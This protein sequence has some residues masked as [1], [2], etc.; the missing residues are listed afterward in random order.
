MPSTI[1]IYK[2]Q[3]C[4]RIVSHKYYYEWFMYYLWGFRHHLAFSINFYPLANQFHFED[5]NLLFKQVMKKYYNL[6]TLEEHDSFVKFKMLLAEL[7]HCWI[8]FC[9][10]IFSFI[11]LMFSLLFLPSILYL[12]RHFGYGLILKF[13]LVSFI[14]YYYLS[15][16][17]F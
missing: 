17:S 13:Y 7:F 15:W 10:F 11:M 14:L 3:L 6:W 8:L 12:K 2:L 9:F 16:L 4:L 1:H 5:Q